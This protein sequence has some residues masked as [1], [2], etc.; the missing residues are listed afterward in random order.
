MFDTIP[1]TATDSISLFINRAPLSL[2]QE[3]I[4][5]GGFSQFKVIPT[6]SVNLFFEIDSTT[7]AKTAYLDG[8]VGKILS[9]PTLNSIF[10]LVF[11]LCFVLFAIF[12]RKEGNSLLTNF[13]KI[14][15]LTHKPKTS[16]K[17]Q[18]T[19]TEAWGEFFLIL[20]TALITTMALFVYLYN[21]QLIFLEKK[22]LIL[23]F[24]AIFLGIILF[25]GFK[26]L[27]YRLTGLILLTVDT[28]S[29]VEKYFWIIELM[30]ILFF[31]PAIFFV[32]IPEFRKVALILLIV[33]FF[34]KKTVVFGNLLNIFAKN[35]IGFLY[36]ILYLCGVE[37]A[38]YLLV[39]KGA[40]LFT[41]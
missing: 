34:I 14:F 13:K 17:E 5:V 15:S 33:L 26:Y 37:I 4:V 38:P 12:M 10:F 36:Y 29:W 18:I 11:V 7:Y 32:F 30:G 27:T 1:H 8:F 23:V 16:S 28:R 9:T 19:N 35:K 41:K 21:S 25:L 20:Q 2:Q 22:E 24:S 3:P 31:I 40:V 39:Y 6:D